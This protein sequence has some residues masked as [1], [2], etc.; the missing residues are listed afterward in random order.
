MVILFTD[1][2]RIRP[3][4]RRVVVL[5]VLACSTLA[6][7]A[8]LASPDPAGFVQTVANT[9]SSGPGSLRAAIQGAISH[10]SGLITFDI[11]NDCGPRV[12]ELDT[13]LPDITVPIIFNGHNQPGYVA[14]TLDTGDNATLCIVLEAGNSSVANGLNVPSG[15]DDSVAVT[16]W[17]IAF[18]GFSN[19]GVNLLG[20][21]GHAIIAS[22]FGGSA[23]GHALQPND[24]DIHLG[25]NTHDVTIGGADKVDRNVIGGAT[26]SGVGLVGGVNGALLTGTYNNHIVGNMIGIDWTGGA[27]GHFLPL[28]N[29]TRGIIMDA[30]DNTISGNW[31]AENGATGIA[32]SGGGASNNTIEG[33]SIGFQDAVAL[34]GNGGAGVHLDGSGDDA[35]T[36]NTIQ[37]NFIVFND[38]Q[39][40]W[41]EIGQHNRIFSN[42][43][44]GNTGLGIDLAAPGVLPNDNDGA[45][46]VVDYANRG[47]NFPVLTSATGVGP[48]LTIDGTISS[49]LG[50]YTIDVYATYPSCPTDDNR[51]GQ[52]YVGSIDATITKAAVGGDGTATVTGTIGPGNFG[53]IGY[54]PD[55]LGITGTATD[56]AGNT[57]EYSACIPYHSD[58]IFLSGFDG[59]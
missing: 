2:F 34:H 20:G 26:G 52:E 6:S 36:G 18:S 24:E 12:I 39:G 38:A 9:N 55:G 19:A 41:V 13:P 51:Q 50:S 4:F 30:H 15:A 29:G 43:I 7:H 23:S 59:P 54:I 28:G 21:S 53:G 5:C 40:V 25:A 49:T 10:G 17:G 37:Y 22:R 46:Q 16:V 3:V 11:G 48:T 45:P 47:L 56:S 14:N 32:L 27:G 8:T 31:I 57:S 58:T 1:P 44:I 42:C 35:P 33:N